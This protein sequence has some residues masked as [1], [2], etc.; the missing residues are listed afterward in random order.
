MNFFFKDLW[1]WNWFIAFCD[2]NALFLFILPAVSLPHSHV[3]SS[4]LVMGHALKSL[5][6]RASLNPLLGSFRI[7][8]RV[9]FC[10]LFPNS[11]LS[12]LV[13]FRVK[14]CFFCQELSF[15]LL[16]SENF[17]FRFGSFH[18]VFSFILFFPLLP[19]DHRSFLRFLFFFQ[20]RLGFGSVFSFSPSSFPFSTYFFIVDDRFSLLKLIHLF[21]GNLFSKKSNLSF[22]KWLSFFNFTY[23]TCLPFLVPSSYAPAFLLYNLSFLFFYTH[24]YTFSFFFLYRF[25]LRF[26]FSF[27]GKSSRNFTF[28]YVSRSFFNIFPNYFVGLR[29]ICC[30]FTVERFYGQFELSTYIPFCGLSLLLT[31][32]P[33]CGLSGFFFPIVGVTLY[34]FYFFYNL[35]SFFGRSFEYPICYVFSFFFDDSFS[36]HISFSFCWEWS[37][38]V[39]RYVY[40]R[41]FSH[42]FMLPLSGVFV[43]NSSCWKHSSFFGPFVFLHSFSFFFNFPDISLFS[44]R[45]S[46][47]YLFFFSFSFFFSSFLYASSL[48]PLGF[49]PFLFS[50][51]PK[52]F[53][54]GPLWPSFSLF[55]SF[56]FLSFFTFFGFFYFSPFFFVD[57]S[58]SSTLPSFFFNFSLRFFFLDHIRFFF[59]LALC[60]ISFFALSLPF[61]SF[62]FFSFRFLFSHGPL[63]PR[64]FFLP[65]FGHFSLACCCFS[66]LFFLPFYPYIFSI[67]S[68]FHRSCF[69]WVA[70]SLFF[71]LRNVGFYFHSFL[72]FSPFYLFLFSFSLSFYGPF[73]SFCRSSSVDLPIYPFFLFSPSFRSFS[74]SSSSGSFFEFF[75]FPFSFVPV[76]F[77][78][79]SRN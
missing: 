61:P 62:F 74:T 55:S 13:P 38:S 27:V 69:Y 76:G 70:P 58:V 52:T 12:F 28:S 75:F 1:F 54:I 79:M 53:F 46:F 59:P 36:F 31:S 25:H 47:C 2:S 7:P 33:S 14:S 56:F 73:S 24:I 8:V 3:S 51:V 78:S 49:S 63:A 20:L 57:K 68:F 29:Q 21:N 34:P 6:L 67:F 39:P 22:A 71:P 37:Y 41:S 40:C 60:S 43:N 42:F 48:F 66:F 23:S 26:S 10:F 11:Q 15:P 35:F 19:E 17:F 72:F 16:C 65:R 77:L 32:N 4:A 5:P 30:L 9:S 45:V 64:P 50:F 44:H 18:N